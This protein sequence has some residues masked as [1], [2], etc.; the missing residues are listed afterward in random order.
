MRFEMVA[1]LFC[2]RCGMAGADHRKAECLKNPLY[3]TAN[4]G[5]VIP[6]L[7]R[8]IVVRNDGRTN[9]QRPVIGEMQIM[10]KVY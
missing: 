9:V 7:C 10:Q 1:E 2:R 3:C 4:A 8:M 5:A 6:R